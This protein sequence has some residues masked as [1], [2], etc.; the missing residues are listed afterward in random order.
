MLLLFICYPI[1]AS[2]AMSCLWQERN[3][4]GD[5]IGNCL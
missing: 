1:D 2:M 5:D 4:K 3:Y